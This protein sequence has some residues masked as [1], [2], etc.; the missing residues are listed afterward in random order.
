M[1][2]C[3]LYILP[4][5]SNMKNIPIFVKTSTKPKANNPTLESEESNAFIDPIRINEYKTKRTKDTTFIVP[6]LF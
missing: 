1:K 2:N 5:F 3:V 4:P 6:G